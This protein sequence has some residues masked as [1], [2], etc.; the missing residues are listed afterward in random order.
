MSTAHTYAFGSRIQ[1]V[2]SFVHK[3]MSWIF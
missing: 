2:D 1:E 3:N